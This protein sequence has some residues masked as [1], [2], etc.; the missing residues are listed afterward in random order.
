MLGRIE[1]NWKFLVGVG[2]WQ[3]ISEWGMLNKDDRSD[4]GC[5]VLSNRE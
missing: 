1:G 2:V 5:D 3:G 4:I